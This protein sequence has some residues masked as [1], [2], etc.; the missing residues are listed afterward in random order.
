M[1]LTV[2]PTSLNIDSE[3]RTPTPAAD[4]EVVAS[5]K[6]VTQRY[7]SQ[8]ARRVLARSSNSIDRRRSTLIMVITLRNQSDDC[9]IYDSRVVVDIAR[10]TDK[11]SDSTGTL[12]VL[13][14][15]N[16]PTSKA[17]SHH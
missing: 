8:N 9:R 11:V 5:R 15:K 6:E 13:L 10:I 12:T 17:T 7:E 16:S 3:D 14:R 4:G 1:T 2:R